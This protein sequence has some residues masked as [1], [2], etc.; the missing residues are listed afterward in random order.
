MKIIDYDDD[1]E[2]DCDE[3]DCGDDDDDDDNDDDGGGNISDYL[4]MPRV[5]PLDVQNVRLAFKRMMN[6]D[7]QQQDGDDYADSDADDDDT[8][9]QAD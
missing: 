4:T 9:L 8:V 3:D 5:V 6:D 7:K 2:I 1:Y